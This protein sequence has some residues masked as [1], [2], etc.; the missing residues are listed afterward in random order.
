MF[1]RGLRLAALPNGYSAAQMKR[2]T[3]RALLLGTAIAAVTSGEAA[4]TAKRSSFREARAGGGRASEIEPRAWGSQ[5]AER[6]FPATVGSLESNQGPERGCLGHRLRQD[7]GPAQTY[8]GTII[9]PEPETST[10]TSFLLAAAAASFILRCDWLVRTALTCT[11]S[12]KM[13][14]ML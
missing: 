7:F 11:V 4:A 5:K 8:L 6:P 2:E 1:L 12:V 14:T 10:G 3:T 9:I 13:K